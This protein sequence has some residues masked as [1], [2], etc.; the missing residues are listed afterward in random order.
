MIS[1]QNGIPCGSFRHPHF[2]EQFWFFTRR[3][4]RCVQAATRATKQRCEK[5]KNGG[6]KSGRYS[7]ARNRP[8]PTFSGSMPKGLKCRYYTTQLGGDSNVSNEVIVGCYEL[9][10]VVCNY[11][12]FPIT[13]ENTERRKSPLLR[14]SILFRPHRLPLDS[15]WQFGGAAGHCPRVHDAYSATAFSVITGQALYF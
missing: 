12:N 8:N 3:K 6:R 9:R 5:S 14:V 4:E 1:Y 10:V 13:A 7:V 15:E 2:A 11:Q